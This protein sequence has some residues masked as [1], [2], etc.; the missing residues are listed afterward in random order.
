MAV[1]ESNLVT[2]FVMIVFLALVVLLGYAYLFN[3]EF[4]YSVVGDKSFWSSAC[5][6]LFLAPSRP[7]T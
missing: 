4:F 3:N 2:A 1:E 6:F 7:H 5:Q